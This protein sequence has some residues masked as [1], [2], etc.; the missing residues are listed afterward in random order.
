[1]TFGEEKLNPKDITWETETSWVFGKTPV[2]SIENLLTIE[3]VATN[4]PGF[5]PLLILPYSNSIHL[6]SCPHPDQ[7]FWG[8]NC[9]SIEI[10]MIRN[11]YTKDLEIIFFQ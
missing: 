5:P 3:S 8:K 11:E 7:N 4:Y 9:D 6:S 2:T 1:M 10:P